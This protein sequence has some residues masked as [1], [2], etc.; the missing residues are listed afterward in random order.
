MPI[1]RSSKPLT[2][3]DIPASI[4]RDTETEA[5]FNAHLT[6]QHPHFQYFKGRTQ[7]YTIDPPST[8]AGS[9]YRTFVP[10]EGA[11]FG[12]A[13]LVV[14][15]MVN[16]ITT[17]IWYFRFTGIIISDNNIGIYLM[18]HAATVIDLAPFQIRVV[19]INV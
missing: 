5:A 16:I 9:E 7:V 11:K 6:A 15:I 3:D 1:I 8:P 4:A 18:N 10:F 17:N 13:C 14:P 2:E 19:V 12:D